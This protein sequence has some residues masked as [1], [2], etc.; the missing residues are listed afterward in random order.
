MFAIGH[1]GRLHDH[2]K[3]ARGGGQPAPSIFNND[4]H[5]GIAQKLEP[6]RAQSQKLDHA[7]IWLNDRQVFHGR[8]FSNRTCPCP[9]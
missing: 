9:A 1:D 3:A 4:I 7:G 6:F 8:V 5:L 2:I